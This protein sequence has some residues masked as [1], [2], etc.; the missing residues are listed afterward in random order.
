VT[1]VNLT[2]PWSD[3]K[4]VV[5]AWQ[6][7]APTAPD[8]LSCSLSFA[9]PGPAGGTPS[10]ALNGQVFGTRDQAISLLAPLTDVVRPTRLAAVQRRFISAVRYFASDNPARRAFAAKS[11]YRFSPLPDAAI[12][13][14][15]GAFES[16]A[17][18]P[19]LGAIG[20]LLFAHGGAIN[21]VGA[22]ATAFAH[23][24]ALFSIRFTA[25]WS[26]TA[27]ADVAE[28]HLDWV[29]DT[30]ATLQ[31]FGSR[32]AVTNYA[33]PELRNSG[34]AY[35]GSHLRRLVA[36]KRHYDPDDFFHFPQSIPTR[37]PVR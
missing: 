35:Y 9:P 6:A 28:A 18:D 13:A 30:H 3:A 29:R 27:P 1:T 4:E 23:R 21:R 2:W 25:F 26:V 37:L 12:D 11:S 7:F 34:V 8:S 36:V 5:R 10:I 16:A 15:I 32:G 31:L 17:L 14:I 24:S 22:D 20:S 19:R 33:D